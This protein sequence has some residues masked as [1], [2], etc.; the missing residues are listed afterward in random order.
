MARTYSDKAK[1]TWENI[2]TGIASLVAK[3]LNAAWKTD[4]DTPEMARV[5][6][7]LEYD[8]YK[9]GVG[10]LIRTGWDAYNLKPTYEVVDPMLIIN[11]P[12]GD[13]VQDKY[14]FIG[15]E[16]KK[17]LEELPENWQ[18][19]KDLPNEQTTLTLRADQLKQNAGVVN[20]YQ[21]ERIV[22]YSCFSYWKGSLYFS[23]WGR[24]RTTLL[25][26]EKYEPELPEEK[27]NNFVAINKFVY[28]TRWKA[29][30]DSY[31]GHRLAIFALNVQDARSLIATLR[32]QM[33][34]S[35][36]YPMY[37]ANT[38]LIQ[39]RTDLDFGFNKV[40]FA[41]PMEGESLNNA[42]MP[43]QKDRSVANPSQVDRELEQQL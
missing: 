35:V 8:K 23:V 2:G 40:I 9:S 27:T 39:D 28:S 29:K 4:M 12:D 1:I 32:F 21:L 38:R 20:P 7:Q 15:F 3:N 42:M 14:K 17:F 34:K 16:S 26:I 11:D 31:F 13:Y 6:Y 24:N 10:T 18:N 19:T 22:T 43:I 5:Q 30:R 36:L 25:Y 37:I 41:N 33:E